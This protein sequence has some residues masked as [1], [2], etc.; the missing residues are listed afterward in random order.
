MIEAG[1]D[2]E[3]DAT[4]LIWL[5]AT[6]D[7]D[8]AVFEPISTQAQ[9]VPRE[10]PP[11]QADTIDPTSAVIGPDP[12]FPIEDEDELGEV[13]TPDDG[14][15][16]RRPRATDAPNGDASNGDADN[17]QLTFLGASLIV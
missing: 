13:L 16:I 15:S 11:E 5:E 10:L 1:A 3:L 17:R 14:S 7:G 8:F 2:N 6:A 12:A 4:S 9:R